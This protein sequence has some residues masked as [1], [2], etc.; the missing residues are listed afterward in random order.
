MLEYHWG[1]W[2]IFCFLLFLGNILQPLTSIPL[3][4]SHTH[5]GSV[6]RSPGSLGG[7]MQWVPYVLLSVLRALS[8][9]VETLQV[10]KLHRMGFSLCW[11][12]HS[13]LHSTPL[14]PHPLCP[15]LHLSL[16]L[17]P[18]A[19]MSLCENRSLSS[20]MKPLS[21]LSS[22]SWHGVG[23]AQMSEAFCPSLFLFPAC[24]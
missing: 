9:H 8:C 20:C 11:E 21:L 13:S 14:Y 22:D 24:E 4:L 6:S 15:I 5:I 17:S 3:I 23:Q 12:A 19:V 18:K 10:T 16:S 7:E 2:A 1:Q